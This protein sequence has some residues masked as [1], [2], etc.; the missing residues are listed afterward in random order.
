MELQQTDLENAIKWFDSEGYKRQEPKN[1][2]FPNEGEFALLCVDDETSIDT[3]NPELF[4]EYPYKVYRSESLDQIKGAMRH[5]GMYTAMWG[6]GLGGQPEKTSQCGKGWSKGIC[7][8]WKYAYSTI[9]FMINECAFF[10]MSVIIG[11]KEIVTGGWAEAEI[12]TRDG[13]NYYGDRTYVGVDDVIQSVHENTALGGGRDPA[14][15]ELLDALESEGKN[16][17]CTKWWDTNDVAIIGSFDTT[18]PKGVHEMLDTLGVKGGSKLV[19]AQKDYEKERRALDSEEYVST[20]DHVK[21]RQLED[22]CTPCA[23]AHEHYW[24]ELLAAAAAFR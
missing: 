15:K 5:G 24:S 9:N 1:W 7:S 16:C 18:T 8:F 10:T 20:G 6:Y 3:K 19:S 12:E 13:G 17:G 14:E 23:K 4:R 2:P 11:G 22:R 21:L